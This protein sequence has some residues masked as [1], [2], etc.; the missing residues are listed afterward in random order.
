MPATAR[1][2][3]ELR[4]DHPYGEEVLSQL[5]TLPEL[6]KDSFQRTQ[7]IFSGGLRVY[8]EYDPKLS[9]IANYTIVSIIKAIVRAVPAPRWR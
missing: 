7:A 3:N 4:A 8:T 6:G 1:P 2:Q 5:K 9:G